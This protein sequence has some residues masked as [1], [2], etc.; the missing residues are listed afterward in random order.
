M[1]GCEEADWTHLGGIGYSDYCDLIKDYQKNH[2]IRDYARPII[3]ALQPVMNLQ[4]L[5]PGR[6]NSRVQVLPAIEYVTLGYAWPLRPLHAVH[7]R[8]DFQVEGR[9]DH[10]VAEPLQ[11]L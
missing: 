3:T 9:V 6:E 5:I 10:T 7:L 11:S 2:M 4:R 1:A 8:R